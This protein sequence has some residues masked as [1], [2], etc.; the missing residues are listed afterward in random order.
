MLRRRRVPRSAPIGLTLLT[1]LMAIVAGCSDPE[2]TADAPPPALALTPSSLDGEVG[3]EFRVVV[4]VT[5][6]D[7]SVL[8]PPASSTDVVTWVAS[9]QGR[10]LSVTTVSAGNVT[11]SATHGDA[12]DVM[13]ALDVAVRAPSPTDAPTPE[14]EPEPTPTPTP[15]PNPDDGAASPDVNTVLAA[16]PDLS[17]D[18]PASLDATAGGQALTTFGLTTTSTVSGTG[19]IVTV[20]AL[21]SVRSDSW[22]RLRDR[23][24]LPQPYV[25]L[26]GAFRD[27]AAADRLVP[28][29]IVDVGPITF[30]SIVG[31]VPIDGGK[32]RVEATGEGAYE[33][34]WRLG[35][36][37]NPEDPDAGADPIYTKWNFE[38]VDGEWTNELV[39]S[40]DA[41]M[42][43][44][45]FWA[46][47]DTAAGELIVVESA[48]DVVRID[49]NAQTLPYE[50]LMASRS[51]QADTTIY[52]KQSA[53]T[54][55]G[56]DEWFVLGWG[57]DSNGGLADVSNY[58]GETF[59]YRDYYAQGGELR[60]QQYGYVQTPSQVD[61]LY[62]WAETEPGFVDATPFCPNVA[63]ETDPDLYVLSTQDPSGSDVV[64]V[65]CDA[66]VVEGADETFTTTLSASE[67]ATT[68]D[69]WT[70]GAYAKAGTNWAPGDLLLDMRD[71]VPGATVSFAD[72]V[73]SPVNVATL[74]TFDVVPSP[75]TVYDTS[76]ALQNRYPL[77][78]V[79]PTSQDVWTV[80]L[81]CDQVGC[82]DPSA[83][84]TP[85]YY[86]EASTSPSDA[87]YGTFVQNE[88]REL[89]VRNEP[90]VTYDP[91][92]DT[93]TETRAPF[94]WTS[95]DPIPAPYE[96]PSGT[97]EAD[98]E[99]GLAAAYASATDAA[100]TIDTYAD[101]LLDLAADPA[102]DELMDTP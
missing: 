77:K 9:D 49:G 66:S 40:L 84:D 14:P 68:V 12:P 55:S 16:I 29:E 70:Y 48:T 86:L 19:T 41:P 30:D 82:A 54:P 85:V 58:L 1:V 71:F 46:R 83:T 43:D 53:T 42:T 27:L 35:F 44:V 67:V 38:I 52:S 33:M 57:N 32:L 94:L 92:T 90:Y 25:Q 5:P 37:R 87:G 78:H 81:P 75:T 101:K 99:T 11:L 91:Q 64:W 20:D 34:Y 59:L 23:S 45:A 4:S 39:L 97:A 47:S 93:F 22:S 88:D 63:S 76:F 102:F 8:W 7:A 98:V 18:L 61:E 79:L 74:A 31:S 13:A 73:L 89:S 36:P 62:G 10:T 26:V 50:R 56:T 60:K 24:Q 21:P 51:T 28:G 15:S 96:A 100:F 72:T 17:T 95:R 3:R 6:S 69:A 2:P 80:D 65:A